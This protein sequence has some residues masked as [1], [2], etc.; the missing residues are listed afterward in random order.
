MHPLA[1][2]VQL[3]ALAIALLATAPAAAAQNPRAGADAVLAAAPTATWIADGDGRR[4][5]YIFFDPNCPSCQT[6]YQNLRP[7]LASHALQLRWIPVAVVNATS[8]GKAAA[9]LE[10]PD[11]TAA[12]RRNEEHYDTDTYA[13]AIEEQIPSRETEQKLSANERLL[14][15]LTIPVV[16]SMLFADKNGRA[17]IIQGTLSPVALRKV[18]DRLP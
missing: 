7:F 6:L 17:A 5:V 12:F 9:I 4:I 14:N 3:L 16:P 13:G 2:L 15:R 18:F 11:P 8:A 1:V 10:A